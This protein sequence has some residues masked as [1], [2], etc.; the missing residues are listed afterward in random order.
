M[1]IDIATIGSER[2]DITMLI[3]TAICQI[4]VVPAPGHGNHEQH[5]RHVFIPGDEQHIVQSGHEDIVKVE[6]LRTV[7]GHQ[8][9]FSGILRKRAIAISDILNRDALFGEISVQ[10]III[11]P[12]TNCGDIPLRLSSTERIF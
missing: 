1:N 11:N 7:I 2:I 12:A 8:G 3:S 4:Q 10:C 9:Y 5:F 6:S